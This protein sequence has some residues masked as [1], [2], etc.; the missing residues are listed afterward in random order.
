VASVA[1]KVSKKPINS[2]KSKSVVMLS[3]KEQRELDHIPAKIEKFEAQQVELESEIASV[4]FYQQAETIVARKLSELEAINH[5][6]E[7]VYERW[8]RLEEKKS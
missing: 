5:Q 8:D 3:S 4:E 1:E 2:V 6:L 7:Q